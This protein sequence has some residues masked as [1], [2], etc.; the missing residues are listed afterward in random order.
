MTSGSRRR[1][2]GRQ[3]RR[4]AAIGAIAENDVIAENDMA[5]EWNDPFDGHV[6]LGGVPGVATGGRDRAESLQDDDPEDAVRRVT[7]RLVP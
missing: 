6:V 4:P 3:T 7:R 1:P 5:V 2:P